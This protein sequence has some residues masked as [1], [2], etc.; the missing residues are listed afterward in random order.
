MKKTLLLL[1]CMLI[2]L[3]VLAGEHPAAKAGEHPAKMAHKTPSG[4]FDME[5]C[6][7]CQNL[8]SQP[9]L[10]EHSS[11]ES[12][13]ISDG[14]MTVMTVEP[15]Y[16][17][18]MAKASAGM[19]ATAAKM[20]SGQ[21]DMSKTKMCGFCQAYGEV[22]MAGVQPE[23]VKGQVAEVT[24]MRSADP[25]TVAKLHEMAKRTTAEMAIMM[26]AAADPHAGHKH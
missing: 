25:K 1:A 17:D 21:M 26:G 7:F 19:E 20:H 6:V 9:G 14:M 24:L 16:A 4:W 8:T 22:M 23:M 5:N 13:P 2:A 12:L 10:L 18:A 15:Q 11:W 3:P